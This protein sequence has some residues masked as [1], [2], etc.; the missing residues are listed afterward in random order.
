MPPYHN[1]PEP[2]R[3]ADPGHAADPDRTAGDIHLSL[4]R[5]S[6]VSLIRGKQQIWVDVVVP[7][8]RRH[9]HTTASPGQCHHW[10][11]VVITPLQLSGSMP[12]LCRLVQSPYPDGW[13]E[14]QAHV[15]LL[16]W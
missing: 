14:A 1:N 3:A 2:G 11:D 15:F 7:P 4:L 8:S 13:L 12:S 5:P 10:I 6:S 16:Y 9:S